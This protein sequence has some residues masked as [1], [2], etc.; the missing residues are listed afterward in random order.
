MESGTG[1]SSMTAPAKVRSR[2]LMAVEADSNEETPNTRP[3]D[4]ND[5][6]AP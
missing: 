1:V 2:R 6:E 4:E 5:Q 3:D